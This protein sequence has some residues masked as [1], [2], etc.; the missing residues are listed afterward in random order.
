MP[1]DIFFRDEE[2]M[3]ELEQLALN[4]CRGKVLDIGAGVGSHTLL[5]QKKLDATALEISEIACRIMQQ[6]GVKKVVHQD[7]FGYQEEKFDTLLLLMNGIGLCG[8]LQGL[9]L[10]LQHART[11]LNENGQVIFDSSDISY[12][13]EDGI[14]RPDNYYGEVQ[15]QYQYKGLKGPWFKWLYIDFKTLSRKAKEQGW[16]AEKV[17]E[18]E[19]DQYLAVLTLA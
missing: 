19:H 6:R 4:L 8:D 7:F 10:F 15:F 9:E 16:R 18:D 14:T 3:P 17:Y 5:L 2:D 12:L 13:Y 1:V 11:L